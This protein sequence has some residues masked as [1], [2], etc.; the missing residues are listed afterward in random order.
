MIDK[1][2]ETPSYSSPKSSKRGCLC[3]DGRTY[4]RKCCNGTLRGQG[5]GSVTRYLFH[6]YTEEGEKFTQENTHKLYQ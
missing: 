6:L 1:M 3:K 4:S 2:K 5:V